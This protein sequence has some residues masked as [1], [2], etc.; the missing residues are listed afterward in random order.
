MGKND[1]ALLLRVHYWD[2]VLAAFATSLRER[3]PYDLYIL[4][5]ATQGAVPQLP[6]P[7]FGLTKD[8]PARHGL[9][10]QF[11]QVT[12]RCGDYFLYLARER[13]PGYRFYW[14]LE[15]DV[16]LNFTNP[17]EVFT[18]FDQS[19]A[20]LIACHF[21]PADPSWDWGRTMVG[22]DPIHRCAYS[23]VRLS[24]TAI[25]ALLAARQGLAQRFIYEGRDQTSW[26][27]DEAFTAT[28]LQAKGFA[29]RDI[30]S[31]GRS[32]Y[33]E[34]SFSF[35][36]PEPLSRLNGQPPD[37]KIHHPVLHGLHLFNKWMTIA[38]CTPSFDF[39]WFNEYLRG[40]IGFEWNEA[41]AQSLLEHVRNIRAQ[42]DDATRPASPPLA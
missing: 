14:M 5:D 34:T 32:L 37:N 38:Y 12:W 35:W 15:H 2:D 26:P 36:R 30:N 20:D 27:N 25:D 31:F 40:L 8:F 18:T 21:N 1:T 6:H 24:A 16:R 41:Q 23:L 10:D 7:T 42:R 17:G 22:P 4:A 13:L 3:L 33:D 39:D 11:P 19:D 29:C 28:T 9:L